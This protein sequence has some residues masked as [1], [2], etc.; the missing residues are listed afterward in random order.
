MAMKGVSMLV[1]TPTL[2]KKTSIK[3]ASI[4]AKRVNQKSTNAFNK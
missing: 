3:V 2:A 1:E 4:F